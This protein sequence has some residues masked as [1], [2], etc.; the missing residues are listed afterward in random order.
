MFFSIGDGSSV[1]QSVSPFVSPFH[2]VLITLVS[3]I[4]SFSFAI[5]RSLTDYNCISYVIY[6]NI[7]NDIK[8]NLDKNRINYLTNEVG[9]ERFKHFL[10]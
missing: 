4:F 10:I 5:Y 2:I 8:I 6:E 9:L 3:R 7:I 1:S